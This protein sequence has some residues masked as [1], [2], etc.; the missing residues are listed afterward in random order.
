[1][2]I[3]SRYPVE[4]AHKSF[5]AASGYLFVQQTQA[6][7][8]A[9]RA[10]WSEKARGILELA[11]GSRD[12]VFVCIAFRVAI[13]TLCHTSIISQPVIGP[14]PGRFRRAGMREKNS[15]LVPAAANAGA[16][17]D[18]ARRVRSEIV[19]KLFRATINRYSV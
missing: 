11:E 2:M 1:M 14:K 10:N 18:P 5:R 8:V 7:A 6:L 13:E 3:P 4:F 17:H 16:F 15:S 19:I 12:H 9:R